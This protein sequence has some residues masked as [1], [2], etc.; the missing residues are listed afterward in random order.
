MPSVSPHRMLTRFFGAALLA[1][2]A[3]LAR[4]SVQPGI[5]RL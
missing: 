4:G 3:A 5:A 2:A 1:G